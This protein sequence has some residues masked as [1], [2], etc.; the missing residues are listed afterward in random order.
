MAYKILKCRYSKN[1]VEGKCQYPE[2]I[3]GL[4]LYVNERIKT[5]NK[6]SIMNY[7]SPDAKKEIYNIRT[8]LGNSYVPIK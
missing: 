1:I 4:N 5:F 6:H 2:I 8:L 7:T 3:A